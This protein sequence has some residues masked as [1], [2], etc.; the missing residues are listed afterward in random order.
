M[1]NIF[2]DPFNTH[3]GI[4]NNARPTGAAINKHPKK[5]IKNFKIHLKY[6]VKPNDLR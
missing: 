4:F 3:K 5:F 1:H 2:D 6:D